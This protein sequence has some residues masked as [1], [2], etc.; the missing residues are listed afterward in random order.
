MFIY[1][2]LL[3]TFALAL[4]SIFL[5]FVASGRIFR[6][7]WSLFI[8]GLSLGL[9]IYLYGTWIYLSVDAKWGF[10]ICLL[11]TL[12]LGFFRKKKDTPVPRVWRFIGN[13]FFSALFLTL[14]I[15][16]FTGTTGKARAIDL[17]FPLKTGRYFVLQGG[18]GLPT[19]LFHFSLR[20]AIYAMDI[21]KLRP[22]GSRAKAI[23]SSRLEDYEIYGDTLYSPCA[24]RIIKAIGSDP[25]NIPP[26]MIRGPHN[27]N[28]VLIE[29]VNSY[30]FL[31]HLKQGSVIVKEGD[32]VKQGDPLGC[33][34]NSGFSSEPHL[35]IQAHVKVPGI[36]WYL[37]PPRY[38]HFNGR[39]YLLYEVI[40]PQR[41]Q[42]VKK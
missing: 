15:L 16:Y 14:S 4:L 31:A 12:L 41:V 17:A 2:L 38:I 7:G 1:A 24:G 26:D 21:V 19:N 6:H 10:G 40:R 11:L 35:H 25:D 34:G 18:K 33:V 39:G 29:T 36:P 20:G 28:Q 23:F 22:N 27:T 9:F 30:V 32:V 37:S 42:M 5:V 13:M 8:L 3:L